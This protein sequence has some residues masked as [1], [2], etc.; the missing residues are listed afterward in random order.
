MLFRSAAVL[1]VALSTTVYA[2]TPPSESS[3]RALLE[4]TEAKKLVEDMGA[5]VDQMMEQ[6]VKQALQGKSVGAD[7]EKAIKRM[8]ER[9]TAVVKEEMSWESME[10]F[11]LRIYRDT[12]SQKEIDGMLAFYRSEAGKA[13]TRKM[14]LVM[15]ASMSEVQKRIPAMMSK[16]KQIQ[17]ESVADLKR[18][19]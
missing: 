9:M 8:R 16:M 15:Q 2:D 18:G 1:F 14:P 7:E 17:E 4:V 5:Q 10:P 13:V 19:K 6:T 11:Y 3:L 12:F